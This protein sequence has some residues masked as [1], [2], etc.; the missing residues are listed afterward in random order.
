MRLF[1]VAAV[2]SGLVLLACLSRLEPALGDGTPNLQPELFVDTYYAHEFTRPPTR[3]RPYFTQ[4]A[5]DDEAAVNLAHGGVTLSSDRVR[6]RVAGQYGSSVIANYAA[7][8]RDFWRYVQEGYLGVQLA[9]DLWLDAGVFF[10]HIGAEGW[11][12]KD[13]I[14]YT[15]SYVAEFSPYY[16]SGARLDWKKSDSLSIQLLL[17]RGWQNISDDRDW[18]YGS[19][20]KWTPQRDLTITH[21]TFFGRENRGDREFSDLIFSYTGISALTISVTADVG[22]Q[23]REPG[24]AWW[25]GFAGLA[26]YQVTA[27]T[28]FG[29]RAERYDDP[30]RAIVSTDGPSF[31]ASGVSANIDT[32]LAEGILWRNELRGFFGS[33]RLFPDGDGGPAHNDILAITSLSFFFS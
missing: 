8:P 28:A 19:Q 6:G 33:S 23:E 14:T 24:S 27:A 17:L 9:P 32:A 12:S 20:V 21:N 11:V 29:L 4:P 25:W 5:Y 15:R 10:A 3:K 16:E 22:Q 7:E 13:N 1:T 2:R 31:R 18:G 30:H 26:K